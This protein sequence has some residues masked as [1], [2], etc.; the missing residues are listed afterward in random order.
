M[1]RKIAVT[2]FFFIS[3]LALVLCLGTATVF[4]QQGQPGQVTATMEQQGSA[5]MPPDQAPQNQ[6]V[7]PQTLTLPAGTVIRIRTNQ[8]LSSD[9]NFPGDQ[10]S[11]VLDQPIVADGWVVARRGQE[12]TGRVSM[13]QKAGSRNNNASQLGV[14]LTDLALVNGQQV[15]IQTQLVQ[16]SAGRS[17]G[18]NAAIVGSTAGVGAA[19]G[20]AVGGGSGAAAGAIV[21]GAAGII[22][23]FSTHGRPTVIPPESVISFRLQDPVT[24]STEQ[25][26]QAFQPV[27]QQDYDARAPYGPPQNVAGSNA[28][29]DQAPPP[30]PP[31]AY[32]GYPYAYGYPYPYP[33]A[34]AYP[35][36]PY[37]YPYPF[38]LGFYGGFGYGG[39]YGRGFGYGRGGFGGF[40]GGGGR[41]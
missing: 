8:W 21:G 16:N 14:Q 12:E 11:A 38:G 7:P 37:Y 9:R 33:Y 25:G 24:I 35:Y 20:A 15:P 17:N 31:P 29:G 40:R 28:P 26:Q 18:R 19:I 13:A 4:A 30:P 22:G 41:R 1:S 36:Y 34:Y 27:T 23:A 39:F 6:A 10:F 3:S 32:Y 2:N 5:Q